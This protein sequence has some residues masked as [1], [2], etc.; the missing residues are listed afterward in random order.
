MQSSNCIHSFRRNEWTVVSPCSFCRKRQFRIFLVDKK[1]EGLLLSLRLLSKA[2]LIEPLVSDSNFQI[3]TFRRT[4]VSNLCTCVF[5]SWIV[6]G[7]SLT[8]WN[9]PLSYNCSRLSL[10]RTF[11][12]TTHLSHFFTHRIAGQPMHKK[13]LSL[14]FSTRRK[15]QTRT[16]KFH[17]VGNL[18]AC[19]Y[20]VTDRNR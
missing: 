14:L 12:H 5:S 16:L 1:V 17:T 4:R 15:F 20:G 3:S 8:P 2:R 19:R 13:T 18:C 9:V 11:D 10:F 6:S 7:F